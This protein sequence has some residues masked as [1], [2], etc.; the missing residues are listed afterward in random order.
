MAGVE[1]NIIFGNGFKLQPSSAGDI[2]ITN[3]LA[4]DISIISV[5]GS[6]AGV[7][8]ANPSSLSF[9]LASGNIYRKSSATD[10][11]GWVLLNNTP[12][13]AA[14][15][16]GTI[17]RSDGA[18]WV[19]TT[20]TYPN[21]N[22]ISTLLYASAANVMSALA[23]ANNGLLVTSATGVPSILAGPAATGRVLQ[24]NAAAAPSFSTTTYPS[25]NA[26]NTLLYASAAN[27]MSALATAN[28]GLLVTSAT[29][30]PSILAGPAATGRVLQSNAAAA[31][32]FS[33]TTYPSTNAI[34]TL[35]YASAANVMSALPT[36][37]NGVLFTSGT[38]VPS[39]GTAPIIVGGTNANSFS[40][41]GGNVVYNGTSLVTYAGNTTN[42]S[43]IKTNTNQPILQA[44]VSSALT[45]VTGDGTLYTVVFG[46]VSFQQG[47]N[48]ATGTGIYTVPVTGIY[49]VTV[50][51]TIN[52]LT[53][54]NTSGELRICTNAS[55][56]TRKIFNPGPVLTGGQ[57]SINDACFIT[58]T[59]TQTIFINIQV[60]GGAKT[61][62]LVTES[63][64]PFCYLSIQK[65]A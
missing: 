19:A 14:G 51:L 3:H 23:T 43:G 27:V 36:A 45:N 12:V 10:A 42:A 17:L 4:T 65:I 22:A 55:T 6:P 53:V 1:K 32:S 57:F 9:D 21:T 20:S 60:S 8:S 34:N 63:F 48:Y 44:Y 28:N 2:A 41:S 7:V 5:T 15:G 18:N 59:A 26:I 64:G 13:P 30:V 25:T 11:T 24:S 54:A 47:S 39:I 50:N 61:A 29:G 37:N 56:I 46:G 58:L 52:N 33:T 40:T 31:P 62:G 38:G 35:L 49:A 16:V